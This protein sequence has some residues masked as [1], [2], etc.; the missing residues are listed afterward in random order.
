MLK[1]IAIGHSVVTVSM[2]MLTI[3]VIP[4]ALND[5]PDVRFQMS[6]VFFYLSLVFIYDFL[7]V[8]V[9]VCLIIRKLYR[10]VSQCKCG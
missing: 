9:V 1:K 8:F 5:Q 7:V 10:E 2:V 3:G 4:S 6:L